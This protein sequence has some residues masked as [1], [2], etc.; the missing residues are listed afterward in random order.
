MYSELVRGSYRIPLDPSLMWEMKLVSI[1]PEIEVSIMNL[2]EGE[3]ATIKFAYI[4]KKAGGIN[5]SGNRR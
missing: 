2:G 4:L 3:K 1:P 5:H